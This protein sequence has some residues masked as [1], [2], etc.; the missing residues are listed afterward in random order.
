MMATRGA[1]VATATV[2]T[3]MTWPVQTWAQAGEGSSGGMATAGVILIIGLLVFLGALVKLLDFRRKR[4]MEAA[5]MQAQ[6]SDA[7]LRNPVLFSV[8]L[9]PT[10]RV[11][12]WKGS[13]VTVEV[14]GQVP[15]DDMRLAALRI[16]ESEARHLRSDV[17]I[18][19][20][21]GVVPS[22]PRR[23]A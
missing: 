15:S 20:R 12:F 7:L 19:S 1:C 21:I 13:P 23:V 16:I 8:P 14:S 18:E 9:T 17:E 11:P 6:V 3:F 4:E 22:M 10:A 5:I 2:V